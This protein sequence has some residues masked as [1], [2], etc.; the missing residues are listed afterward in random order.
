MTESRKVSF[1][2]YLACV[3]QN[4]SILGHTTPPRARCVFKAAAWDSLETPERIQNTRFERNNK[5]RGLKTSHRRRQAS[6]RV[7]EHPTHVWIPAERVPMRVSTCRRCE[8]KSRGWHLLFPRGKHKR[9]KS[10]DKSFLEATVKRRG[11]FSAMQYVPL[12]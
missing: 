1:D 5:T 3:C 4:R 9:H 2:L 12:S 11:G 7:N 10:R 8:A 6:T